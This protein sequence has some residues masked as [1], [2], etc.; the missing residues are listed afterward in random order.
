MVPEVSWIS[1]KRR[2]AGFG[3]TRSAGLFFRAV[4]T[5]PGTYL[6]RLGVADVARLDSKQ[7]AAAGG[8]GLAAESP[9]A[10]GEGL[11][12]HQLRHSGRRR[13]REPKMEAELRRNMMW[14]RLMCGAGLVEAAE[15]RH[16]ALGHKNRATP[17]V[18][19]CPAGSHGMAILATRKFSDRL[20]FR[21]KMGASGGRS[22]VRHGTP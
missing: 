10:A 1:N 5:S 3:R 16:G 11:S 12:L 8:L 4:G 20:Y 6:E 19:K 22:G 9:K 14:I 2:P 18:K 7:Y 15:A 21:L 13:R 17:G